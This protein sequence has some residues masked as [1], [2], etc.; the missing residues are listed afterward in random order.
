MHTILFNNSLGVEERQTLLCLLICSNAVIFCAETSVG[1]GNIFLL[2]Q[3]FLIL[4]HGSITAVL[5]CSLVETFA[6]ELILVRLSIIATIGLATETQHFC[7]PELL[8]ENTR[9]SCRVSCAFHSTC[10]GKVTTP[11]QNCHCSPHYEETP[12]PPSCLLQCNHTNLSQQGRD[13]ANQCP[14][15]RTCHSH[16]TRKRNCNIVPAFSVW[17]TVELKSEQ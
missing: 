1:T 10:V 2:D 17:R 13:R 8:L 9:F 7:A 5:E 14:F 3:H 11:L 12:T 15:P 16:K 6:A 4:G